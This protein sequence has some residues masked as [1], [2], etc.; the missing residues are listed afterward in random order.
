VQ[1]LRDTIELQRA[2]A[3]WDVELY[4]PGRMF[5]ARWEEIPDCSLANLEFDP[6]DLP[7][8]L[9]EQVMPGP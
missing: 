6:I 1:P 7:Q 3:I 2:N 5:V 9:T 8:W 4:A